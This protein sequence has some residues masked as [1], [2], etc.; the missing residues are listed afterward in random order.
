MHNDPPPPSTRPTALP[1]DTVMTVMPIYLQAPSASCLHPHQWGQSNSL[2][3]SCRKPRLSRGWT[4][5]QTHTQAALLSAEQSS[6]L[7]L[8]QTQRGEIWRVWMFVK[9]HTHT[10]TPRFQLKDTDWGSSTV[11]R[12]PALWFG[13]DK[14]VF[15]GH[16]M[17]CTAV[18]LLCRHYWQLLV[19]QLLAC[20]L[21]LVI[22]TVQHST[23]FPKTHWLNG[24]GI[25]RRFH[26]SGMSFLLIHLITRLTHKMCSTTAATM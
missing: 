1:S 15:R 17:L 5:T 12:R 25:Q 7:S 21:V 19:D 9:A 23:C 20:L 24:M 2:L 14:R 8:E 3:T 6:P 22:F 16:T 18:L 13:I 10:A 11:C 26:S 4:S